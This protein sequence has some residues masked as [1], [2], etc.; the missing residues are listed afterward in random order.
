MPKKITENGFLSSFHTSPSTNRLVCI[1]VQ[2]GG[3]VFVK[4]PST[5]WNCCSRRG[6]S[7]VGDWPKEALSLVRIVLS[8][9][10]GEWA[11]RSRPQLCTASRCY[12]SAGEDIHQQFSVIYFTKQPYRAIMQH[13]PSETRGFSSNVLA[14]NI[15]GSPRY[16]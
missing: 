12:S 2:E 11:L 9:G 13:R 5:E 10:G 7:L 15:N 14:L 16:I 3:L 1:I 8:P 4:C 6:G